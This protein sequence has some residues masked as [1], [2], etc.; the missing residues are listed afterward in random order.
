MVMKYLYFSEL[1]AF[2]LIHFRHFDLDIRV[3]SDGVGV[4]LVI[5]GARASVLIIAV[6][7]IPSEGNSRLK[8]GHGSSDVFVENIFS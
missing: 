6:L 4:A 1:C 3:L 8:K 2:L 7:L 5:I